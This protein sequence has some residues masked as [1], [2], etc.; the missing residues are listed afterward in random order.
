[1]PQQKQVC[2]LT[3]VKAA[4]SIFDRKA[5]RQNSMEALKVLEVFT[6]FDIFCI[7]LHILF[8]FKTPNNGTLFSFLIAVSSDE[9]YVHFRIF[10]Y[11][12]LVFVFAADILIHV[13]KSLLI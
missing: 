10:S 2:C 4:I 5:P 1:M 6:A 12:P 13:I 11:S 9:E 8:S 3:S 7:A